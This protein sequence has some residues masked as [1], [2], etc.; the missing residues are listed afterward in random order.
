MVSVL[1][2]L[3]MLFEICAH[4]KKM[5]VSKSGNFHVFLVKSIDNAELGTKISLV[6][7]IKHCKMPSI[8]VPFCLMTDIKK[9]KERYVNKKALKP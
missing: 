3:K 2:H 4:K 1:E 8:P 5:T 6:V 7:M 9:G